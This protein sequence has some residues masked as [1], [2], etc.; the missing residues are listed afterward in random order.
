MV[1]GG[2]LIHGGRLYVVTCNLAGTRV[3]KPTA[4]VCIGDK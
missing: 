3:N 4:I 1:Y 2:P